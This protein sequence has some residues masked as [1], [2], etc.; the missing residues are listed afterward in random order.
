MRLVQDPRVTVRPLVPGDYAEV[1]RIEAQTYTTSAARVPA[2]ADPEELARLLWNGVLAQSVVREARSDALVG[3]VTCYDADLRHGHAW[4]AVRAVPECVGDGLALLGLGHLVTDLFRE[5][6]LRVL[7]AETTPSA[8][9]RFRSALGASAEVVGVLRGHRLVAGVPTDRV[10][11]SV[12]GLAWSRS[13]GPRL[14]RRRS[15]ATA[16]RIELRAEP[17]S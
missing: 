10:L 14:V 6:P 7:Y 4:V 15:L 5:W 17:G 16:A 1:H 9:R 2:D 8:L 12:D 3:L 11:L 13:M